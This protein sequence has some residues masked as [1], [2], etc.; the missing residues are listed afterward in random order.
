MGNS[1]ILSIIREI[2]FSDP[3]EEQKSKTPTKAQ[4]A[5]Q[6]HRKLKALKL[7]QVPQRSNSRRKKIHSKTYGGDENHIPHNVENINFGKSHE[8]II[9]NNR[10][11]KEMQR[12]IECHSTLQLG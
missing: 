5:V 11:L 1:S 10:E 12:E 4:E 8:N 2:Y 9:A 6:L 7:A 3:K